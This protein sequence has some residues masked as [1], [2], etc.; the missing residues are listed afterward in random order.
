MACIWKASRPKGYGK[1]PWLTYFRSIPEVLMSKYSEEGR[2]G[3]MGQLLISY[4]NARLMECTWEC[5]AE[6]V[7]ATRDWLKDSTTF[8]TMTRH[9]ELRAIMRRLQR[10]DR[11]ILHGFRKRTLR[12]DSVRLNR[13]KQMNLHRA[14]SNAKASMG[15]YGHNME[16]D[17]RRFKDE[18]R[19][20]ERFPKYG[21]TL[22]ALVLVRWFQYEWQMKITDIDPVGE[23]HDATGPWLAVPNSERETS[24]QERERSG[25][26][27]SAPT[28][29]TLPTGQNADMMQEMSTEMSG[30]DLVARCGGYYPT[31]N[32]RL[33]CSWMRFSAKTQ[34]STAM[35]RS[36]MSY[37]RSL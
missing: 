1:V 2:V 22:N 12:G 28:A 3:R 5:W 33:V 13:D 23:R 15:Q 8:W 24:N 14:L 35:R 7:Q 19:V 11:H 32:E 25:Y 20:V 18:L 31:S 37:G 17:R 6:A 10:T 9:L 36:M 34:L 21:S 4:I 27:W 29:R 16:D 30:R 26:G